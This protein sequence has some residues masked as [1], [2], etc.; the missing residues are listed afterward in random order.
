MFLIMMI[1]LFW[2]PE[3]N[4]I[5][6]WLAVYIGKLETLGRFSE[7]DIVIWDGYINYDE[8]NIEFT[9]PIKYKIEFYVDD[10]LIIEQTISKTKYSG[11]NGFPGYIESNF[12]FQNLKYAN[13]AL[14]VKVTILEVEK[15]GS[16]AIRDIKLSFRNANPNN[17]FSEISLFCNAINQ[18]EK[19][20]ISNFTAKSMV[21]VLEQFTSEYV[22]EDGPGCM[23]ESF[24]VHSDNIVSLHAVEGG[25]GENRAFFIYENGKW[26]LFKFEYFSFF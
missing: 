24:E 13:G 19:K 14:W 21:E 10:N 8:E 9:K 7:C 2:S 23:M 4:V 15:A 20:V 6:E 17:A 5:N 12:D 11:Y 25:D 22:P 16:T 26:L 3:K 1:K 18:S